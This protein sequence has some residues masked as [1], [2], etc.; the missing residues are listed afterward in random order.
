MEEATDAAVVL[1]TDAEGFL[2]AEKYSVQCFPTQ[3]CPVGSVPDATD[4]KCHKRVKIVLQMSYAIT[5][6]GDIDVIFE[7]G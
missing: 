7:P 6:K 4:Y 1:R 3:E 2:D 5:T